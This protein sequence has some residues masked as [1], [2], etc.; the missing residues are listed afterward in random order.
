MLDFIFRWSGDTGRDILHDMGA[1][2][3]AIALVVLTMF[4]TLLLLICPVASGPYSATHGPASALRCMRAAGILILGMLLAA[5]AL[6]DIA[7]RPA[8]LHTSVPNGFALMPIRGQLS[9]VISALRC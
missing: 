4:C 6:A 9:E 7:F 1:R 8:L 5:T 2:S 3:F